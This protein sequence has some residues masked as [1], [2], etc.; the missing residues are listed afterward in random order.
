MTN[1]LHFCLDVINIWTLGENRYVRTVWN[2]ECILQDI[3]PSERRISE[4]LDFDVASRRQTFAMCDIRPFYYPGLIV[5]QT[6]TRINCYVIGCL[7]TVQLAK[8]SNHELYGAPIGACAPAPVRSLISVNQGTYLQ[9]LASLFGSSFI[10]WNCY[11]SGFLFFLFCVHVSYF[12]APWLQG[13]TRK[14]DRRRHL[15]QTAVY[16]PVL[17]SN[18]CWRTLWPRTVSALQNTPY[19][20]LKYFCNSSLNLLQEMS[21][22]ALKTD[23][24][25]CWHL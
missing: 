18:N 21:C 11:D 14:G 8:A 7:S 10:V 13:R 23:F 5:V 3:L 20:A 24:T 15:I 22:S 16:P 9:R 12:Y 2:S 6:E 17:S 19:S 1:S 25:S 4:W